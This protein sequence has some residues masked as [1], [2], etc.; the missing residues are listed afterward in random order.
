MTDLFGRDSMLTRRAARLSTSI[1]GMTVQVAGARH[2]LEYQGSRFFFCC[3]GC[4]DRFAA[5]PEKYLAAG[6]SRPSPLASH[7]EKDR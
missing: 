7:P 6:G 4:L 1:C 5:D 2:V 3:A